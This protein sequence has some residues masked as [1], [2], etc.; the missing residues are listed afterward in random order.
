[1]RGKY[2]EV[3]IKIARHHESR[4]SV[5]KA[6][7]SYKKAIEADPLLEESYRTLML[8]YSGK[9]LLNEALR[10]YEDCK[11]ALKNGLK[12]KP[13]PVTVALYNK[14]RDKLPSS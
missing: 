11:K 9:G 4:G 7:A 8:L 6:M 3:M 1:L 2:I 5:K 12:T 14:I 10:V 13:D